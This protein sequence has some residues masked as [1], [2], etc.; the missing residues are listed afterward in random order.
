MTDP[1]KDALKLATE[2]TVLQRRNKQQNKIKESFKARFTEAMNKKGVK[3]AH[4][5][6]ETGIFQTMLG[7]YEKGDKLPGVDFAKIIA[8][9]FEVSLDWLCGDDETTNEETTNEEDVE[10]KT[11]DSDI[12]SAVAVAHALLI[13]LSHFNPDIQV[14]ESDTSATITFCKD[15]H[16]F[17]G[18]T[19]NLIHFLK[20]YKPIQMLANGDGEF[21]EAI[22]KIAEHLIDKYKNKL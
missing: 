4:I 17:T 5:S 7:A 11:E 15:N 3:K 16:F 6:K 12:W 8:D 14:N 9:Y 2:E 20:D 19:E 1:E 22:D 21:A 10:E 13:V 18:N